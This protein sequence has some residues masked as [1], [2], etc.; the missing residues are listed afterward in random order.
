M[1]SKNLAVY[2]KDL[3]KTF[4][5]GAE[6]ETHVLRGISFELKMG[7]VLGVVGESGSGKSTLLHI[8]GTLESRT[9]GELLLG[10]QDPKKWDD[11]RASLFRNRY[12]GFVFQENNLL[13]DFTALENV[14]LPAAILGTNKKE[15]RKK[16]QRL[17]E[18]VGL[19]HRLK[20]YPGQLS[21]GEQQR[22]AIARALINSPLM[23][24]AD[25]PTGSLDTKNTNMIHE[26]LLEINKALKTTMVI[27]T[28][29][30]NFASHLPRVM[31]MRD[32]L[33]V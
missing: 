20:H 26:L 24:L 14:V 5:A 18:K 3:G 29:N 31:K 15:A 23:L 2:A 22:V 28:H 32:G 6:N 9:D 25:E 12:L 4:Q 33:I 17:L 19:S 30:P 27:V 13:P 21:G 11:G 7:E 8:L 16:A 10:G 1:N